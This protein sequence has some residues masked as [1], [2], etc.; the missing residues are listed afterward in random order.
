MISE[1]QMQE[2]V[3]F[4]L[5]DPSVVRCSKSGKRLQILSPG[6][7]NVHEGPDFLEIALLIDGTVVV[8]D[9]EF[10]YKASD[11]IRHG[12]SN[13]TAYNNVILHI[14]TIDDVSID[15]PFESLI[16]SADEINS[17]LQ[18]LAGKQ[19]NE[20]DSSSLEELQHYALLRLLRKTSEAQ[21]LINQFGLSDALTALCKSFLQRYSLRR[22]RP[23]YD[24]YK[25]ENI[26][27]SITASMAYRFLESLAN[28]EEIQIPDMMI[29]L[30]KQKIDQEGAHMR[31]E[32]ILNCILPLALCLAAEA[33]RINLFLWFWSTPAISTYGILKRKFV[34]YPQNFLWQQQ[35]M[36][37]YVK[38][39][40]RKANIVS[41][42]IKEYGFGEVLSFYRQGRSPFNDQ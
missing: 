9:A 24:L 35:G 39:H 15:M 4:L 41:D 40:G 1:K 21:K 34:G 33:S 3:Q 13:N 27:N 37:E 8:G 14:I 7:L 30:M 23:G 2:S 6:R 32:L 5:S 38:E 16:V 22:R 17:G 25:M 42:V 18:T 12:H 20:A 11:W 28:G 31:R 29:G 19:L 10:H 36:L 26:L